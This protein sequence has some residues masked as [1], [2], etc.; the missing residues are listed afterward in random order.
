MQIVRGN[1]QKHSTIALVGA[2]ALTCIAAALAKATPAELDTG[3]QALPECSPTAAASSPEA[4]NCVRHQRQC[5]LRLPT[6]LQYYIPQAAVLL[7]A[8][9]D[10]QGIMHQPTLYRSSGNSSFDQAVLA[11]ADNNLGF[12]ALKDGKPAEVTAVVGYFVAIRGSGFGPALADG[13]TPNCHYPYRFLRK[14]PS[15]IIRFSYHVQP[16]GKTSDVQLNQSSGHPEIDQ[17]VLDCT[18]AW[19]FFPLTKDGHPIEV[20]E[21]RGVNFG[22]WFY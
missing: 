8:R 12:V 1:G 19:N 2:V 5:E 17:L 15:G 9:I 3:P 11:C 14:S 6:H 20:E 13:T 10:L 7:K 4:Q 22:P 18:R 21:R 16:D